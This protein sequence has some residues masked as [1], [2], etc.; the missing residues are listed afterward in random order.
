M[1][2][3]PDVAPRSGSWFAIIALAIGLTYGLIEAASSQ[4]L[5]HWGG[6]LSWKNGTSI[7]ALLYSPIFYGPAFLILSLPFLLLARLLPRAPLDAALVIFLSALSGLLL[8]TLMGH[9][10]STFSAI[11]IALGVGAAVG[12]WYLTDRERRARQLR[13]AAP[14]LIVLPL[15]AGPVSQVWQR[16]RE[17]RTLAQ[18][19][20]PGA[21]AP[22]VL[23][24]VIDTGR[25]DH[26]S[27]YGNSRETTPELGKLA[28]EGV[29]FEW[30]VS[31]APT[32]LPSHSS[33]FTGRR[34]QEHKAGWGGRHY[35]DERYPTIAEYVRA[36]G[37]ATGGF[38]ANTY[39][40]GRHTGLDR[41]FV[42]YEDFY[43]TAFDGV[44]RTILGRQLA[45]PLLPRLGFIDIPGRKQAETVNQELLGWVDRVPKDRPFFAMANYLDVHAPYL[46]P[47]GYLGKVSSRSNYRPN[48]I[49]IGAWKEHGRMPDST[50][51]Q[52]WRD[53]YD[54]SLM[55]LDH[56]IGNLLDSLRAKGRLENTVVIVT[57]DHG[58]SFGDHGTLHHGG[59][60]HL[61]QIRV[62]LIVWGPRIVARGQRVS[63][64]VDLR[65]ISVTIANIAV[66]NSNP[67]PGRSLLDRLDNSDD[68]PRPA[69]SEAA[70]APGNPQGWQTAQGWVISLMESHWHLIALES[71][72]FEVYDIAVDPGE[73]N[74]LASHPE[75]AR[76][77]EELKD[78]L[79]AFVP[80]AGDAKGVEVQD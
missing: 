3:P 30:A 8:A 43:G 15:L 45:Y 51:L 55:Y 18:S 7:Q 61:E 37:Y 16:A 35:L 26:L 67:F 56:E 74:N 14:A 12:R 77:I 68:Q 32:T 23:L 54:E 24:L 52:E 59:S 64:P 19:P 9:W 63:T 48:R 44:T 13:R 20:A 39:W 46:P 11:M 34:V 31:S 6:S 65:S 58:E 62:P 66:E 10:F 4:V 42:H 21:N 75:G 1:I 41:G 78:D 53:R 71:G 76:V 50:V 69:L 36:H 38:V 27:P 28:S 17:S 29:L 73:T 57:S 2:R 72:Q 49:E 40:A 47:Q 25:G 60:L 70:E 79:R 33:M 22:N 80:P 5:S